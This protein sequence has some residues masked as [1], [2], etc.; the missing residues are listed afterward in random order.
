MVNPFTNAVS[1]ENARKAGN[2]VQNAVS[3]TLTMDNARKAGN[4]VQ[5]A[6]K[7][8]HNGYVDSGTKNWVDQNLNVE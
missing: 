3:T 2:S 6:G 5:S 8:I 7:S 1:M 4:S